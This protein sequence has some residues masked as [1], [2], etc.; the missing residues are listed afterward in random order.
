MQSH[1]ALKLFFNAETDSCLGQNL[2]NAFVLWFFSD[3]MAVP[4]C[5]CQQLDV[6][7]RRSLLASDTTESRFVY[8]HQ[9]LRQSLCLDC[10][11]L[12]C[13]QVAPQSGFASPVPMCIL[14]IRL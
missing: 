12:V 10:K 5:C 13:K 1:P 3:P 4:R 7:Q 8:I 14:Q 2:A 9:A 11:S 6:N